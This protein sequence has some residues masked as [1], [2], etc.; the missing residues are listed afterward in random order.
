[1]NR[2]IDL[3]CHNDFILCK[4]M[5]SGNAIGRKS[6]KACERLCMAVF[7]QK[8]IDKI[9]RGRRMSEQYGRLMKIVAARLYRV[10]RAIVAKNCA[11]SK[12]Q[13]VHPP[14]RKH[15]AITFRTKMTIKCLACLGVGEDKNP[16]VC[17]SF[18]CIN[19]KSE[20]IRSSCSRNT[21]PRYWIEH[22]ARKGQKKKV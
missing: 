3:R 17:S 22:S 9:R 10:S 6:K 14:R 8:R 12:P 1:M 5:L 7:L 21:K 16:K 20:A 11:K 18:I 2:T 19:A 4:T 13:H 15:K